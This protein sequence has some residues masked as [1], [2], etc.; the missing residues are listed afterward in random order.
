MGPASPLPLLG[1]TH[2]FQ[3]LPAAFLDGFQAFLLL[4]IFEVYPHG[5]VL[6]AGVHVIVVLGTALRV[7]QRRVGDLDVV[8]EESA[9]GVL[10]RP[11]VRVQ[12]VRQ[13]RVGFV[14]FLH[15]GRQRHSQG[16]YTAVSTHRRLP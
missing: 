3:A 15:G 5:G 7:G 9:L 8:E 10:I 1:L 16:L 14:D 4:L 11:V 2:A 6:V 12:V 13:L